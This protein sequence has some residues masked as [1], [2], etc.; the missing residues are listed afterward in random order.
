MVIIISL[1]GGNIQAGSFISS[2]L[3]VS[4]LSSTSSS[5][6]ARTHIFLSLFKS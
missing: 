1:I 2:S 5:Y 6:M 4:Q 3:G